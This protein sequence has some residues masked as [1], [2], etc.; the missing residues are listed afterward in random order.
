MAVLGSAMF[1]AVGCDNTLPEGPPLPETPDAVS[2]GPAPH[3]ERR[4]IGT[5]ALPPPGPTAQAVTVDPRASLIVTD[6]SIVTAIPFQKLMNQLVTQSGVPGLTALGLFQSWWSTA[7]PPTCSP[8]FNGFPYECPRNEG[9]QATANPFINPGANPDEYIP[10]ALVN[11]FDLAPLNGSDC[12]E[13]RVIFAR[14]AGITNPGSRNLIIFEAVLP[15]P[16]PAAG[17]SGCMPVAKFWATLTTT[18]SAATRAS[19][20]NTFYFTGLGGGFMPVIHIDNYG[21]RTGPVAT[22]QVR[23]DQFMQPPW[24]LRE[25]KV[26]QVLCS[27]SGPPCGLEFNPFMDATNPDGTLFNPS[28]SHPLAPAFQNTGLPPQVP[29]LAVND[30]NLF[31]MASSNAF[32]SG[33]SRSQGPDNNYL[34]QF[35]PN[36]SPF[37]TNIQNQLTTL[38]SPLTPQDIVARSLALSCA[39]CHQFSNGA[40]LGGGIIWPPSLGF[41]H[42]S[43]QTEPGPFGTRFRISPALT[44][45]FLPH[46]KAVLETFLNSSCGDAVCQPFETHASCSADCP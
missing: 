15:N 35:G 16:N 14:R 46:R 10:T 1:V 29:A 11:R 27:T 18:T 39:G 41:V 7:L 38:G 20:L 43:E 8:L 9:S 30:I 42:V 22:G 6:T 37:R 28:S 24:T 34:F 23:T 17:L 31:N 32:N 12:G 45:V 3:P 4:G 26:R 19:M 5:I 13:Y 21:N 25:F 2:L 33:Q 40:N 36:P 44:S